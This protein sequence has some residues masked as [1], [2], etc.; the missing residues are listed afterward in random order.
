MDNG[1][2]SFSVMELI[3][4]IWKVETESLRLVAAEK[5][6]VLLASISFCVVAF[7]IGTCSLLF[8]SIGIALAL[9]LELPFYCTWIVLGMFYMVLFVL[10]VVF[11][12]AIIIDPIARF[13]SRL[14][15]EPPENE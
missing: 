1:N 5:S 2:N 12:R 6:T 7:V 13:M 9:C 10:L 14:L 11:R 8:L 3:K 15:V 4:Q